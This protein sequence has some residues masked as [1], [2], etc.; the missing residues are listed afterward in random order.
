MLPMARAA[1]A[2][3]ADGLVIEAHP[4]PETAAADGQQALKPEQ[5]RELMRQVGA[6]AAAMG[7]GR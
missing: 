3:G 1:I 2:A 5:F 4:D 7:R 6:I